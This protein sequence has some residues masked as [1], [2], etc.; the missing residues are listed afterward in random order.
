[1]KYAQIAAFAALFVSAPFSAAAAEKDEIA[2]IRAHLEQIKTLYEQRIATLEER[3]ARAEKRA[4]EVAESLSPLPSPR[5]LLRP[6]RAVA[7]ELT[8]QALPLPRPVSQLSSRQISPGAF[9]P[10]ISLILSGNYTR[11][12]KNPDERRF[13]GLMPSGGE[14]LPETRSFNLGESELSLS[15]NIDPFF[16]GNFRLAIAPDNSIGIEEASIQTLGLGNGL[17]LKAGRFLSGVGYLNE[18]HPHEWDFSDAPLPYQACRRDGLRRPIRLSNSALRR[19]GRGV[20][21][22]RTRRATKMAR[23]PARHS[24]TWAETS[25]RRTVGAPECRI[26]RPGL[27]SATM[28]IRWAE[29]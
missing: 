21:R 9:N 1:M 2:Q 23:F 18:H 11:L 20:F 19:R 6:V 28:K 14:R 24:C 12:S 17:N 7:P 3:L 5:A 8:Q 10:E 26:S 16:R 13:Q 29:R 22:R 25:A 27:A 15:A 4:E